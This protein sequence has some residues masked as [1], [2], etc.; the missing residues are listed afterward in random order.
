LFYFFVYEHKGNK[1]ISS[2]E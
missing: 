1:K 2:P